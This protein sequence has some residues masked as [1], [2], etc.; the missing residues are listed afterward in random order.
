MVKLDSCWKRN[1]IQ[2]LK[3][4]EGNLFGIVIGILQECFETWQAIPSQFI[5]KPKENHWERIEISTGSSCSWKR[6]SIESLKKTKGNLFGKVIKILYEC[7]EN[8]QA[9][10]S[11]FIRKP[12]E[13][14]RKRMKI[15]TGSSCSWERN[16]IESLKKTEG[17]LFGKVLE[18]LEGCFENW[19]AIPSQFI[20]KPQ[21]THRKRIEISTGSW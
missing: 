9:I 3:K 6:N 8:L 17:N 1:S 13:N 11:Q 20:R 14:H 19:Q 18:I 21:E 2:S 5:R 4:T 12:K 7:F 10:P 16:S 15:L